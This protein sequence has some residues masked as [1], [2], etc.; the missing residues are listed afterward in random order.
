MEHLLYADGSI[1]DNKTKIYHYYDNYSLEGRGRTN[2]QM[3]KLNISQIWTSVHHKCCVLKRTGFVI[4]C[5]SLKSLL[6][7]LRLS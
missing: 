1:I 5:I 6:Y 2:F 7:N 3:C 4:D